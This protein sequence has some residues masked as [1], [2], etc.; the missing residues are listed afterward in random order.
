MNV[1]VHA[2]IHTQLSKEVHTYI[3]T[4][5]HTCMHAYT[6]LSKEVCFEDKRKEVGVKGALIIYIHVQ[7]IHTYIH[8]PEQRGTF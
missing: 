4:Y 7:Y 8:T 3:H 6:H 1:H 2:Y 5:I